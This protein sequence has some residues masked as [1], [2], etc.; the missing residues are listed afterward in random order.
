MYAADQVRVCRSSADVSSS[1]PYFNRCSAQLQQPS[2]LT[3]SF[4]F[5]VQV[6]ANSVI[7]GSS[8]N[9]WTGRHGLL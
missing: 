1:F 7:S 9:V 8:A 2:S 6:N 5:A 3:T 4:D